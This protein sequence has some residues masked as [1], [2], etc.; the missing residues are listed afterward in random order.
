MLLLSSILL[1]MNSLASAIGRR[2]SQRR[3]SARDSKS[4]ASRVTGIA[5]LRIWRI[6]VGKQM[7]DAEDLWRLADHYGCSIDDLIG[8]ARATSGCSEHGSL[9]TAAA[10]A[11]LQGAMVIVVD[12]RQHGAEPRVGLLSILKMGLDAIAEREVAT[13]VDRTAFEREGE[14]AGYLRWEEAHPPVEGAARADE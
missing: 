7:A 1:A 14:M 8:R 10:P 5:R 3:E 11:A 13:K 6:E 2:I 4:A 9:A 12:A